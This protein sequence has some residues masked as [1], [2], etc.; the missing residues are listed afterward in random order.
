MS[1]FKKI[2]NYSEVSDV[3]TGSRNVIRINRPNTNNA[4][5]LNEL[6][7]FLQGWVERNSKSKEVKVIIKTK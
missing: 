2:I 6:Y 1:N 4:T 7:E 5:A 3:L